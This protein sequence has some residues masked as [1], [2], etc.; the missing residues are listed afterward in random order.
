MEKAIM[1]KVKGIYNEVKEKR[2]CLISGS[3]LYMVLVAGEM[4]GHR[5]YER[6]QLPDL[7]EDNTRI[8]QQFDA[9]IDELSEETEKLLKRGSRQKFRHYWSAF[10]G[11]TQILM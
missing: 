4:Y 6:E 7:T 3:W 11:G 2:T 5:A 1:K 8:S 10:P 9:V